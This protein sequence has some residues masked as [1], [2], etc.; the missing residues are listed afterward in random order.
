MSVTH[1]ALCTVKGCPAP[2]DP[3]WHKPWCGH[4]VAGEHQHWPKRSQGG[5]RIVAFLCHDCHDRIDNGDW[6]NS[7]VTTME[8]GKQIEIY[9][10][11][12]LHNETI[13]ERI[14]NGGFRDGAE[15]VVRTPASPPDVSAASLKEESDG[16]DIPKPQTKD[17][18]VYGRETSQV[19]GAILGDRRSADAHNVSNRPLLQGVQPN[20]DTR[21]LS[22][23]THEQRVAIA[24]AIHDTEWNRQWIAGDTANQWRAELGEEA[25]QYISDFGYVQESIANIM[26]VC[27]AIPKNIRRAE[28]RFSHHVVML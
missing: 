21:S 23:L 15:A 17:A 9:R 12:D 7:V 2:K 16:T 25:E 27:E 20:T 22:G 10:A 4:G 14:I 3:D 24:K 19:G 11:W 8:D 18:E 5:K 1:T 28:L 13:I 6:G 26:R